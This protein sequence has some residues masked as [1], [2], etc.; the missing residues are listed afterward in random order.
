MC[1]SKILTQVLDKLINAIKSHPILHQRGSG[2]QVPP[3]ESV[4][5]S[6]VDV[7]KHDWFWQVRPYSHPLLQIQRKTRLG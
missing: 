1:S 2:V 4:K 6:K 5:P 7:I 3:R